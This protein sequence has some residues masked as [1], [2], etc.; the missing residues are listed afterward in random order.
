MSKWVILCP[1][2]EHEF[3]IPAEDIAEMCPRCGFEGE[4][5]VIDE[6]DEYE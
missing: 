6:E 2:C 4:F 5:E 3:K 1:D